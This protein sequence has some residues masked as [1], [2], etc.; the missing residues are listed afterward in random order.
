MTN[1]AYIGNELELFAAAVH[2]KAYLYAWIAPYLGEDVAEVGAGIGGTTKALCRGRHR[3]WLC[4]EPDP[5]MA[6]QLT[7]AVQAGA[8]PACC[9]AAAC[10]IDHMAPASFDA[11]IYIDV[12][13]HIA[14]DHDEMRRAARATRPGGHVLVLSPAHQWLYTPFDQAIGHYRRYSKR[15]LA[16]AAPPDLELRRLVYLDAAGLFAS[17]GNRLFLKSAMPT[18]RQI[19][20]WDG[21]LVRMSRVL[22]PLFRYTIG[23]SV[24]GI[25]RKR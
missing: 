14:E 3:R 25:W 23:K 22:D 15:T 2:W 4:L 21:C 17:L 11:V 12:L 8:L 9:E 18:A 10:T 1:Y 13:E 16:A 5:K 19:A 24:L 20:F 7:A 6:E